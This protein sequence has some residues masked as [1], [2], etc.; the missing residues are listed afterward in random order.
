MLREKIKI[1]I[2]PK[3]IF[4][5]ANFNFLSATNLTKQVKYLNPQSLYQKS[6]PN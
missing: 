6:R 2:L 5:F 4:F 3:E 1:K